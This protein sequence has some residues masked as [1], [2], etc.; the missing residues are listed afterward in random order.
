MSAHGAAEFAAVSKRFEICGAEPVWLQVWADAVGLVGRMA[1][2]TLSPRRAGL[3]VPDA[4]A[5]E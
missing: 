5:F 1:L 2:A 3:V 4:G